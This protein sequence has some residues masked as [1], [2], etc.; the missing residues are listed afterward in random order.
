MIY[1]V[2][3]FFL[4]AVVYSMAGLG[5]GSTYIAILVLFS[6]PYEMIPKVALL[7]NLIV[8]GGGFYLFFRGGHFSPKTVIPFIVTSIPAAYFGGSAP[9]GKGLFSILLAVS[10]LVAAFRMLMTEEAFVVRR[11]VSW[12]M[13]WRIGL[14]CGILL[15]GLAGLVGIGGGIFLS[16][17]LYLLGWADA[18]KAAAASS[19]FILVN[20]ISG[21]IGQLTKGINLPEMTLLIPFGIA[22]LLGGQIGARLGVARIPRLALQRITAVLIISVALRLLWQI[23]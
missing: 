7:C 15:G 22:V 23:A 9:I 2:P 18:K 4:T 17:L 5:G 8:A 1:L 11:T 10:L 19:F 21:L 13:A 20:S 3:L 16:P 12:K 6:L 14:P